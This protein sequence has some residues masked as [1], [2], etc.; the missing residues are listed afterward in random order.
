MSNRV[1]N[2]LLLQIKNLLLI[3]FVGI[4]GSM[5][6][7]KFTGGVQFFMSAEAASS[8]NLAVQQVSGLRLKL[9]PANPAMIHSVEFEFNRNHS[10]TANVVE[11]LVV[12]SDAA[13]F[14]CTQSEPGQRWTCLTPGLSLAKA[15][16][17][18]VLA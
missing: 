12:G 2:F 18:Q 7:H 6:I 9:N 13:R 3:V 5:T 11:I 16:Q 10:R 4:L 8:G 14:S 17:I 1:I 15:D